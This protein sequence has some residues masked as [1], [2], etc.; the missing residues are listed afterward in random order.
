MF[1][2]GKHIIN[3]LIIIIIIA[4]VSSCIPYKRVTLMQ[5]DNL[6]DSTYALTFEGTELE[7]TI[8]RIQAND[9]L[10]INITSI[11]EEVTNIFQ[12]NTAINYITGLNQA[13]TGYYVNDDG[14]IDFPYIGKI[15]MKGQTVR[16]AVETIKLATANYVDESKIEVKL[17]NNTISVLGEVNKQGSY[18]ITKTK[19]NIYEAITLAAGFTDYAKRNKVKVLR[20]VDGKN[21]LFLVDLNSGKLIGKNMFFVYPNDV[22]Y[23]EPLRA[24]A[25]GVTPTFSLSI[26]TTVITF[27]ILISS[28]NN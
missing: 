6:I 15:Y 4:S 2:T 24:K 9:Y 16:E 21:K 13:L 5:Y 17:I 20:K 14:T 19:L 25:I 12:P 3:V 10:Y 1:K 22:I 26:I 7:D 23:V 27:Y 8:Y 28:L 11:D 18:P